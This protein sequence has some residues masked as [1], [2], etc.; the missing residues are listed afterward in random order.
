[1][2]SSTITLTKLG[3]A[4]RQLR[5]AITLFFDEGDPV[6]TYALAF[7]SYEIFHTV[8]KHRDPN[9]R[10]LLF[11]S[12]LIKDEFRRDWNRHVRR[13]VNFFKHGDRD[14]EGSIEFNPELTEW[15]LLYATYARDLCGESQ[16]EEE[17][18]F[19]WWLQIN[20]PHLL[21][22]E[23]S[24]FVSDRIPINELEK[25]RTLT[26]PQ[27]REVWRQSGLIRKRP[28]IEIV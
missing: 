12:F 6:S 19:T 14:P 7:A 3:A 2:N 4:H 10:D 16:S 8:S 28:I 9:R 22:E 23:G 5:T 1:M 24:K 13:E 20:K 25:V 15:F 26:R 18:L 27:F 11:D 21:T 17:T